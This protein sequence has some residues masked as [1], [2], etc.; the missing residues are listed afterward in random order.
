V[1]GRWLLAIIAANLVALVTLVFVYPH[2]M[3]S[4]GPLVRG[5]AELAKKCFDCHAPWGGAAS[6]RC[7]ACHALPYIGLRTS[8]GVALER[9]RVKSSFHQE[10]MAQDC[11]ACHS[12]HQESQLAQGGRKQFSHSLLRVAARERCATC[13]AAPKDDLHHNLSVGCGQCHKPE[14]WKPATFEH[15]LLE[16]SVLDRC[17][18]CHKSPTDALHRQIKDS[19]ARCHSSAHWKPATFD[20]LKLFVLD[21]DHNPPCATCHVNDDFSRYTCYGCHE[22]QPD[23]MRAKHQEEG[24]RDFENCVKCHRSASEKHG[25][26]G[27]SRTRERD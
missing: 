17:E 6:E 2:F 13:H 22:H 15:A 14:R 19:C 10:L 7:V 12:D 9:P 25:E 16:K 3:L 4:P 1:K 21:R 24:I 8:K 23:R 5:H 27:G 11:M 26:S 18:G 20:H